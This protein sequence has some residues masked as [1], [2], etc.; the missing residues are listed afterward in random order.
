M[1]SMYKI[2]YSILAAGALGGVVFSFWSLL[3]LEPVSN[4][5]LY[6]GLS[7]L[8]GVVLGFVNYVFVKSVLRI[9]VNKFHTLERVLVGTNPDKLPNV[10]L[11]NE[12]DEIEASMVRITEQFDKLATQTSQRKISTSNR[13]G[14]TPPS[15]RNTP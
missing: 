9:F 7:S 8:I 12:I 4:F 1:S 3:F 11:S 2:F 6:V 10:F 14:S 5:V 15:T 13:L